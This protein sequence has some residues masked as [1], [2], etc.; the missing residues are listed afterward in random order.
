MAPHWLRE[1]RFHVWTTPTDARFDLADLPGAR[2]DVLQERDLRVFLRA[3][4]EVSAREVRRR[5]RAQ[6]ECLVCWI[7]PEVAAYRWDG[8]GGTYLPYLGSR[9]RGAPGDVVVIECRT[10]PGRRR[11][12]ASS[13]LVQARLDRARRQGARRLIGLVA[14]WNQASLAWSA[15]VGWSNVGTVGY[16]WTGWGRRYYVEGALRLEGGE[17]VVLP[18]EVRVVG[19]A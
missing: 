17:V 13:L 15:A 8:T 3:C 12:G 11:A 19:G 16:R 10:L 14:A 7:G 6:Q 18:P 1:R 2:S 5:W 4:R 9:L